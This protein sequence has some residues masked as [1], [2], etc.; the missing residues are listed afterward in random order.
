MCIEF[1][2]LRFLAIPFVTITPFSCAV[3]GFSALP[4][5]LV[6]WQ[7]AHLAV[8][9]DVHISSDILILE[10]P[11][12]HYR[13]SINLV[14]PFKTRKCIHM[15]RY[16]SSS[17][18]PDFA[19]VQY[20]HHNALMRLNLNLLVYWIFQRLSRRGLMGRARIQRYWTREHNL[21]M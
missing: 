13:Q 17:S 6:V 16:T 11:H 19:S 5:Y 10:W 18:L 3:P 12:E 7:Y 20:Q 1:W 4:M 9:Q 15:P 21:I 14:L 8:P 2:S